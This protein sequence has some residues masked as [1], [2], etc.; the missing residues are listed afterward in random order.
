MWVSFKHELMENRWF[1]V[2][3]L[4]GF[5][6]GTPFITIGQIIIFHQPRFPWNKRC[7]LLNH[8]LGKIGRVRPLYNFT[9]TIPFKRGSPQTKP[10]GPKPAIYHYTLG[11]TDSSL[12][13]KWTIWVDVFPNMGIFFSQL[14][15]RL[16]ECS[17][18]E[19]NA[20]KT[21]DVTSLGCKNRFW[22][23]NIWDCTKKHVFFSI[24]KPTFD[25]VSGFPHLWVLRKSQDMELPSNKPT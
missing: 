24:S 6:G 13:G 25:C 10:P 21:W 4:W 19:G 11:S 8:H 22:P 3:V 1:G 18:N 7:P 2:P 14:C 20:K 15:D 12:T 5:E 16:P 17:W 9:R 23:S